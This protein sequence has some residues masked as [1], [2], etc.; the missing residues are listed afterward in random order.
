[1]KFARELLVLFV[2]LFIVSG[3][4]Q[5]NQL[6]AK[7]IEKGDRDRAAWLAYWDLS[8]GEKELAKLHGKIGKLIYFAVYYDEFDHL[9]VPPGLLEARNEHIRKKTDHESYLTFVNDKKNYDG[10]VV[11]KD[12][13]V[14]RRLF[15]SEPLM[16][17]H[18]D[19]MIDLAK[20][21]DF[22]GIEIDYERVWKD[23][24]VGKQFFRFAQ[25]LYSRAR[26]KHLKVRI[27]LEPSAPFADSAFFSGPEYVVML[28]NLFGPHS[29]PG[30]KANKAF[31]Q[32]VMTQ[33]KSLPGEKSVAL[34]TGGCMWT[35]NEVKQWVTEREAKAM[36]VAHEIQPKR[37]PDSQSLFFKYEHNGISYQV[38]YA[39][40]QTINYWNT[41]A[42]EFGI[43]KIN[44]WKLGGNMNFDKIKEQSP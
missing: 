18:I 36:A 13:E 37:D 25:R 4:S 34:S 15:A 1:M 10:T 24:E 20:K 41:L 32:K 40:I 6:V 21:G 29:G 38:W 26:D 39:D 5:S 42:K 17:H 22:T 19:T 30:P 14:L 2:M 16:D 8:E 28:Y 35:S 12:I 31:I 7:S 43:S 23:K 33:M 27:V 9:Y 11:L 3:C 44:L